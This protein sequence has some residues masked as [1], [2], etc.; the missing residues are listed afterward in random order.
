MF[1]DDGN[2]DFVD[3]GLI[4]FQKHEVLKNNS[5]I[6][7]DCYYRLDMMFFVVFIFFFR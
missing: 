3:G 1:I 4:N 2:P 6:F 7:V 5:C